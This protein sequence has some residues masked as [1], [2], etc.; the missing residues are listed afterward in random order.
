MKQFFLI[1]FVPLVLFGQT[2]N[3]DSRVQEK[4][5]EAK[6]NDIIEPCSDLWRRMFV[7]FDGTVNPCDSDYK[8]TLKV[9]STEK[10]TISEL[11]YSEAY[12]SLRYKHL[13]KDRSS[14]SP[15]NGC[16]VV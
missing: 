14:L 15:C 16:T 6:P 13:N 4:I 1:L 10:N 2:N 9:G 11:W 8:S 7:W 3:I 12:N 5:Y